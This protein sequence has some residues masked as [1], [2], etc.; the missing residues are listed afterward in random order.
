MTDLYINIAFIVI[1]ILCTILGIRAFLKDC[2]SF[3][4]EMYDYFKE[5]FEDDPEIKELFYQE[6]EKLK[7]FKK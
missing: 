7:Y 5:G 2:D 6:K 1:I 3:T 4:E